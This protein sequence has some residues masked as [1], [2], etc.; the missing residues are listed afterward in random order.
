MVFVQMGLQM[1]HHHHVPYSTG[2]FFSVLRT[3]L[4]ASSPVPHERHGNGN[5]LT[6]K[7][8]LNATSPAC[9]ISLPRTPHP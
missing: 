3:G 4:Y 2:H 9:Y 7:L 1:N 6:I 5:G 8:I